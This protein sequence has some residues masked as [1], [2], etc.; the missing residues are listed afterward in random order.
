MVESRKK[1]N[2][3]EVMLVLKSRSQGFASGPSSLLMG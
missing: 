1:K 2:M 3:G